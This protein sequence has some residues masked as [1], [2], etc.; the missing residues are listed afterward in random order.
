MIWSTAAHLSAAR[1]AA[2]GGDWANAAVSYDAYLA[3]RP[4]DAAAWVQLGHARKGTGAIDAAIEAYDRAI[5][6]SPMVADHWLQKAM[7]LKQKG[8]RS[9]A[10]DCCARAVEIDPGFAVGV[11]QLLALGARD[12][13][14]AGLRSGAA[15]SAAPQP[16]EDRQN[17]DIYAPSDYIAYRRA[18]TIPAPPAKPGPSASA[19]A[20]MILLIDAR[21]AMPA[22]VRATLMALLDQTDAAWRAVVFA[23]QEICDH[24]VASLAA[25]DGR[26][27][28]LPGEAPWQLPDGA[29]FALL[30][31][32]GTVADRHAVAWFRYT[33]DHTGCAAAYGDHDRSFD[34]WRYGR[35][36]QSP[37]FQPVYDPIWFAAPHTAPAIL[38]INVDHVGLPA[39]SG[40]A[41]IGSLLA[42]AGAIG[43]VAHIPLLLATIRDLAPEAAGA[44]PD[45]PI[46]AAMPVPQALSPAAP[47]SPASQRIQLIVQTRDHPVMLRKAIDSLRRRAAHRDRLDVTIVDNRSREP[48]TA[49]LM[50]MMLGDRQTSVISHDEPFNW[51]RANNLAAA[52]GTAP[53]LLFVNNDVEMLSRHW[54][55]ALQR[56]LAQPGVGAVGALLL[57]P[58]RTIQHGG[59]IMGMGSGGPVHEGVGLP[60]ASPGPM[61]RLAHPRAASAVTGAF[62]AITRQVFDQIGGFD[63]TEL[64]IAFNDVDLCLKVRR[65]G[66]LVVQTPHIQLIHHESKSRGINT[67]RSQ[68]AW[69]LDELGTLYRRWGDGLF[70]DPGYNPHWTRVGQP[71]D[72]YR[73]PTLSE[74]IRHIDRSA[75]PKPWKLTQQGEAADPPV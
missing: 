33:L 72:G 69:D 30:L 22:D 7:A 62:L 13:L 64:S 41:M 46:K 42:E 60:G 1:R 71:F 39:G 21:S 57:Y 73:F 32:A 2:R 12:R 10:I 18:L 26:I 29:R 55:V 70:D 15:G 28:F 61:E 65:A 23:P 66:L 56:Q 51:S 6:L 38:A 58:D 67:T 3:K 49:S 24:S 27:Q 35:C 9:A 34:D 4:H 14:P 47:V 40:D 74:T 50:R 8:N 11:T 68:V 36:H 37:M 59:M 54:D 52:Q 53:I 44:L 20:E 25:I 5:A 31:A 16:A 63:A 45:A 75:R 19:Y 17:G 48:E 43:H